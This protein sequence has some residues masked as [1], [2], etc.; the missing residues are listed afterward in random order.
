MRFANVLVATSAELQTTREYR[1]RCTQNPTMGEEWRRGWHPEIIKPKK[2]DSRV[3]VVGAGPSGLEASLALG[4][5]G[6]DVLLA[7]A[8]RDLGGRLLN[9]AA[10]PG[11]GNW[12][13]VRE[14]RVHML[15][16][17][18]NVEIFRESELTADNIFE[19]EVDHVVVATGS[20]WRRDGV[21]TLSSNV[22][23]YDND[24]VVLTPDD[25]FSDAR[26]SGSITIY[27][28]EHYFMGGALAE[29]FMLAGHAVN[30]VTPHTMVSAW[31]EM[32]NEQIYIQ[33]RLAALGVEFSFS[34]SLSN[35]VGR[36]LTWRSTYSDA[37]TE[38]ETSALVL[39]TGRLPRR[40]LYDE[41]SARQG[42]WA[43]N[44][45]RSVV[46]CWRLPGAL[47]HRRRRPPRPQVC[48]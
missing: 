33:E 20:S 17:L 3:L 37:Q 7:E 30:L 4:R 13:R 16:K 25:V 27:D 8:R 48:S 11:L 5:R 36:K 6:Y 41:L 31:A 38:T 23:S 1:C 14:H 40:G 22:V 46:R 26:F 21:G 10:L 2:S 28:D 42:E 15:D 19:L 24:T 47:H 32:T 45:V 35:A 44:G 12:M 34:R 39:V 18:A 43:D 29:R 9:E